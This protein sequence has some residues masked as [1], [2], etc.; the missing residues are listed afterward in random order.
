[1]NR[2]AEISHSA[3]AVVLAIKEDGESHAS[4]PAPIWL[5]ALITVG[6][7]LS[8]HIFVPALPLVSAGW[9]VSTTVAQLTLSI[10]VLGLGAGQLIYGPLSD[11]FG[12]RP[13]LISG[14]ALY[15]LSSVMAVVS[16]SIDVLIAARLFQGLGAGAGL[17]LGRAIVR[18]CNVGDSA[19][20]ALSL[21][22]MM[23]LLAPGLS[24][25]MGSLLSDFFGWRSI[26][27]VLSILGIFNLVTVCFLLRETA[28]GPRRS[29]STVLDNYRHLMKNR[30][31]VC[32]AVAGGCASTSIYA[33]IAS[34]PVIFIDQLLRPTHEVG[35]FLGFNIVGFAVGS[36]ITRLLVGR[37][38]SQR[39]MLAGSMLSLLGALCF[40]ALM[41]TGTL[42]LSTILISLFVFTLGAGLTIP[43]TLAEAL[44]VNPL[45]AGS[46]SGLY[47]CTQMI[48]GA[49]CATLASFSNQPGIA[50]G[51]IMLG[52][53]LL[54]QLCLFLT[55]IAPPA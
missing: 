6:G 19:A 34:A 4:D 42:Q 48:V 21:L 20:K 55:R 1:M 8:M 51:L 29:M 41:I 39:I 25:I 45:A 31:F 22:N 5:L 23:V 43:L 2:P 38:T 26:F 40:S 50:A 37:A 35:I 7:S 14:I 49:I 3:P 36:F 27:A 32:F 10:Y 13:V 28:T 11:R 54:A 16:P 17:V 52:A 9:G 15:A 33:F 53:T 44:N 30:D 18:D 12:R 46:A 47:G 24:P